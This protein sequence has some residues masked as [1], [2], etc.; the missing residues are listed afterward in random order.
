M[1][2]SRPLARDCAWAAAA[3]LAAL[4]PACRPTGPSRSAEAGSSAADGMAQPAEMPDA[5]DDSVAVAGL[6][7]PF[8][9]AEYALR[10][11]S[12]GS[13]AFEPIQ[14]WGA[15]L[16]LRLEIAPA[17]LRPGA[18]YGAFVT[19]CRP[20]L[21]GSLPPAGKWNTLE[22]QGTDAARTVVIDDNAGCTTRGTWKGMWRC[23]P[24]VT[25]RY[26]AVG[27][28]GDGRAFCAWIDDDGPFTTRYH[29]LAPVVGGGPDEHYD[30]EGS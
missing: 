20:G 29:D 8:V 16:P 19:T 25:L 23:G 21:D 15:V 30:C 7:L 17:M 26:Y 27:Y 2:G 4:L 3:V 9:S 22:L 11:P 10:L 12:C 18:R 1:T 24:R 28:D 5:T 13:S 6:A 14:R